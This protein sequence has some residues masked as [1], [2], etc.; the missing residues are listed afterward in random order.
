MLED[1]FNQ[2]YIGFFSICMFFYDIQVSGFGEH[3]MDTDGRS[4]ALCRNLVDNSASSDI[5][6]A[7]F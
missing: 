1:F 7:W 5:P 4:K 3:A 2:V 6:Q